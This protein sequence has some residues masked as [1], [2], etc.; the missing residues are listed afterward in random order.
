M[1]WEDLR[2]NSSLRGWRGILIACLLVP[3]FQTVLRYRIS[4]SAGGWPL[5]RLIQKLIWLGNAKRGVYI[6]PSARI[7]GGMRMPHPATIVV[8]DDV[9]IGNNLSIYQG[10]TIGRRTEG[11]DQ[12]PVIGDDV[13]IYAGASIIGNVKIGNSAIIGAN[14]VVFSDVPPGA[15]A[16]GIPSRIVKPRFEETDGG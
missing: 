13:V 14:A 8:G 4:R 6:A 11:E 5:G 1:I 12:Y 15:V 2:A 16:V 10:V 9:V 3:G 7:G